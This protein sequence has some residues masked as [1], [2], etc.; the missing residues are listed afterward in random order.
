MSTAAARRLDRAS[1]A[2]RPKNSD[3]PVARFRPGEFYRLMAIRYG[4]RLPPNDDGARFRD[5]MLDT[6]AMSGKDGRQRAIRFLAFRC[7]WMTP[8]ARAAAIE[9]AFNARRYWSPEA[10]GNDLEV[11]EAEHGRARIRTFRVAGMTDADMKARRDAK[12]AA[13]KR[14]QRLRERLDQTPRASKPSRRVDAVLNILPKD[15]WWNVTAIV[16]QLERSKAIVFA[17]LDRETGSLRPAVHR[18]I[19]H[20][21]KEGRLEARTVPGSKMS[22]AMQIKRGPRA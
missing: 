9:A 18:A 5:R 19:K 3:N 14:E 22:E 13:R 4:R 2:S 11:T 12:A 1:D 6:L 21:V 15:G 20:G 8:A 7:D 17:D 10:L 16:S